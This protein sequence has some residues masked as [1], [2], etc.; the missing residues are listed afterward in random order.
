LAGTIY[1]KKPESA[2]HFNRDIAPRIDYHDDELL[3]KLAHMTARQ[4]KDAIQV[5]A[6]ATGKAAPVIFAGSANEAQKQA[7]YG[8]AMATLFPISW[9]EPFGRVMIES[10]ACG[11]PVIANTRIGGIDCGSVRE[12]VQDGVTGLHIDAD[13]EDHSIKLAVEAVGDAARFDRNHVR[14][15]FNR[16]WSSERVANQLDGIYRAYLKAPDFTQDLSVSSLLTPP[17]NNLVRM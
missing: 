14:A 5:I 2:E 1:E 3:T 13:T 4:A 12:V 9:S 17:A 8:H 11:T 7:L 16:D 15:V 10:M 6:A